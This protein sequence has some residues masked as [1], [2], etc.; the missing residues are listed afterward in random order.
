[1]SWRF[2]QGRPATQLVSRRREWKECADFRPFRPCL[3]DN[4]SLSSRPNIPFSHNSYFISSA[5]PPSY[6]QPICPH[7][8]G[9]KIVNADWRKD[10]NVTTETRL[11]RRSGS[12]YGHHWGRDDVP[13][14]L[15]Q[16][17]RMAPAVRRKTL[18]VVKGKICQ[19]AIPTRTSHNLILVKL[20]SH[21]LVSSSAG[22][23]MALAEIKEDIAR[24]KRKTGL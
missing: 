16:N 11:S 15:A 10:P 2:F 4:G 20:F 3:D 13:C 21:A 5:Q 23:E 1:M 19:R 22:H 12:K 6:S 17:N 7:V 9:L 18:G 8:P 24:M 14:S